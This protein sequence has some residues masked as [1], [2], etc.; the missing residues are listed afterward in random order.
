MWGR[1]LIRDIH[2]LNLMAETKLKDQEKTGRTDAEQATNKVVT[3]VNESF[4]PETQRIIGQTMKFLAEGHTVRPDQVAARIQ[5]SADKITST[6]N[7]WGAEFN[8]AGRIVGFGLTLI[9]TQHLYK[10]NGR[11][12]YTWCVGVALA[13]PVILKQTANIE[14]P[15]PVTGE[16]IQV[17]VT[18]ERVEKV[19]PSSG[20]VSWVKDLD[21][22]DVRGT[23]CNYIHFFSSPKTA[24]KWI[25]GRSLLTIFSANN[26]FQ[27]LKNIHLKKYTD[28][29]AH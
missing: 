8:Q 22:T 17:K 1:R 26:V 16:K 5:I 18:P 19:V 7:E 28:L 29:L 11:K 13:L 9:P 27:A 25:A 21:L 15:D 4:D 6:L 12:L 20:V 24:T 3:E 10:A 14:S 23:A 2:N